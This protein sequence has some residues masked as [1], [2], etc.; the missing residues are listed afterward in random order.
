MVEKYASLLSADASD[1][2]SVIKKA[3]AMGFKGLHFD[4][5]DG[6]FVKNFAFSPQIIKSLRKTTSLAFNVHLEILNPGEY[7]DTFIDAGADIITIHPEATRTA[8]R[9]LK[10]LRAKNI[11]GSIALDPEIEVKAIL[12]YLPLVDNVIVMSVYPGFGE[13]KFIPHTLEKIGY[14]KEEINRKKMKITI[15]V[16]GSINEK[17]SGPVMERGADILIFGSSIFK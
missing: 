6:H 9:D 16:D 11:E 1:Y 15:S 8:K 3:E 17:T 2:R 14:L 10:Y 13:Q 5:M 4:V 12:K 7:L